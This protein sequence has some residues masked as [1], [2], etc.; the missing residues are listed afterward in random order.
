MTLDNQSYPL[1]DE[2]SQLPKTRRRAPA[3]IHATGR[4]NSSGHVPHCRNAVDTSKLRVNADAA[5]AKLRLICR[6][7]FWPV[8]PATADYTVRVRRR[9]VNSPMTLRLDHNARDVGSGTELVESE[10]FTHRVD[11]TFTGLIPTTYS[12][13]IGVRMGSLAVTGKSGGIS[14]SKPRCR[15]SVQIRARPTIRRRSRPR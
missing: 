15:G 7:Q 12:F 3:L 8:P 6:H 10:C 9:A 11:V 14:K 5:A 1:A 4:I 2:F 13:P